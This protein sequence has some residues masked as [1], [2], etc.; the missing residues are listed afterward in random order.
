MGGGVFVENKAENTTQGY[1][2]LGW[3][4]VVGRLRVI[5]DNTGFLIN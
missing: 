3:L 5:I 4:G 1:M 2:G